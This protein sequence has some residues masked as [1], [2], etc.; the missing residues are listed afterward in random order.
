MKKRLWIVLTLAVCC[1]LWERTAGAEQKG[2]PTSNRDA[3]PKFNLDYFVGE[4]K[5]ESNLAD[6]PLGAAWPESG[7]ETVRNVYDGRFWDIRIK[8][9]NDR[10]PVT[11][12]GVVMYQDNFAGQ[13][14]ARHQA[15][16]G[17][18]LL[19][20]GEVGCDLGGT[21]NMYFETP[22][23]EQNGSLLRLK[24]R[25]YL[26]SPVSYRLQLQISINKEPY[27]N[28][29]TVLYTK[30]ESVKVNSIK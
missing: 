14:F 19:M 11:G 16:G 2:A 6:S 20:T 1:L 5:F 26:T 4:W 24:G 9:D 25:Y 23:F 12:V 27:T 10:A 21:C 18:A 3:T 30:N 15:V 7:T 22:P 29:G 28:L 8:G 13:F 17:L